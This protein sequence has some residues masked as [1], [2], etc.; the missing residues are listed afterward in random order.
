[1]QIDDEFKLGRLQDREIRRLGTFQD[2]AGIDPDLPEYVT[3]AGSVT[4]QYSGFNRI[5]R[6]YA[7][8]YVVTHCERG[9]LRTSAGKKAIRRY[10]KG[11]SPLSGNGG[12]GG[13]YF[14][15]RA[16]VKED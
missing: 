8:G 11:V 1:M 4:H 10:E 9:E 16:S 7:G 15:S 13:V 14:G 3:K 6:K 12:K 2:A 5:A